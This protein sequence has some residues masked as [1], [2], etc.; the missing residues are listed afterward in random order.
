MSAKNSAGATYRS[1][2]N[3]SIHKRHCK[4]LLRKHSSTQCDLY[5]DA[6]DGEASQTMTL[7]EKFHRLSKEHKRS[8]QKPFNKE[9][10]EVEFSRSD[11]ISSSS[12]SLSDE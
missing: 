6:L 11:S 12:D 4:G 3:K 2:E 10:V 7:A 9:D 8:F 1:V 5:K